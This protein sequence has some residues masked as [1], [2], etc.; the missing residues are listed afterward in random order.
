MTP[1]ETHTTAGQVIESVESYV[2]RIYRRYDN[3]L[4][5]LVE[6]SLTGERKLFHTAEELWT[7]LTEAARGWAAHGQPVSSAGAAPEQGLLTARQLHVLSYMCRGKGN[8]EIAADFGVSYKT[9]KT[10]VSAI[11]KALGV[12]NRTQAVLAA[13][14]LG[15]PAD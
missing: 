13:Q 4:E 3:Q 12:T 1:Q 15:L 14:R 8:K 9:I 7:A 10:H 6:R 5:G 11:L 2:I